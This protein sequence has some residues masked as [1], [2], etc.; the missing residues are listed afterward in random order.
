MSRRYELQLRES[1]AMRA[2]VAVSLAAS[3]TA[4]REL[5]AINAREARKARLQLIREAAH[6][7]GSRFAL[8]LLANH[9]PADIRNPAIWKSIL[10]SALRRKGQ[11]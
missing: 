6:T 9:S 10:S 1:I 7:I 11:S 2:A 5:L 4:S 3:P 8:G